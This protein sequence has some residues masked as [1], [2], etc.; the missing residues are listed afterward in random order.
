MPKETEPPLKRF[1]FFTF[2]SIVCV[3]LTFL[4]CEN[5]DPKI[6]NIYA[7][8]IFDEQSPGAVPKLRFSVFAKI[9]SNAGSVME[10]TVTS[11]SGN[12]LWQADQIAFYTDESKNSVYSG[13]SNFQFPDPYS[14]E[15]G[16]YTVSISS[17]NG[18]V[19]KS[20]FTWPVILPELPKLDS[21]HNSYIICN[22]DDTILYAGK[23]LPEFASDSMLLTVYPDAA[24]YRP[25]STNSGSGAVYLYSPHY[26]EK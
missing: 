11:P 25:Y 16:K 14:I 9:S 23:K 8:I 10:M 13:Y 3:S 21:D 4:G 7:R 2:F 5:R 6:Q 17:I 18:S 1:I 22:Q 19:E 24:Y 20:S 12:F 15:S 26:L